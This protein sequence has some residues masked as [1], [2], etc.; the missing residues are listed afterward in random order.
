MKII[1]LIKWDFCKWQKPTQNLGLNCIPK[2]KLNYKIV[3]RLNSFQLKL[4]NI[5]VK[6]HWMIIKMG[7]NIK[8]KS[9]LTSSMDSL[10]KHLSLFQKNFL[11]R[12]QRFLCRIMILYFKNLLCL[13][14][15]NLWRHLWY[16]LMGTSIKRENRCR[17]SN[18][19]KFSNNRQHL[20]FHYNYIQIIIKE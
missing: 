6:M 1:T 16:F 20:L 8:K 4:F 15:K 14:T 12:I 18:L 2:K 17:I 7:L 5:L 19:K 11:N 10:I 13:R 3:Q 9:N